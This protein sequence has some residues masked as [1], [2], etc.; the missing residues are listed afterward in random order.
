L[1]EHVPQTY[2]ASRGESCRGI[3]EEAEAQVSRQRIKLAAA[4]PPSRQD[5]LVKVRRLVACLVI[6]L[7]FEAV[8][9]MAVTDAIRESSLSDHLP[10]M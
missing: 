2:I 5:Q 1:A 9:E 10:R 3:R 8:L 4:W 7:P 6:A